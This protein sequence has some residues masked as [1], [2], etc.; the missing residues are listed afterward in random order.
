M[1]MIQGDVAHLL[2]APGEQRIADGG[3]QGHSG[4]DQVFAKGHTIVS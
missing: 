1:Q 4:E 2:H 3:A